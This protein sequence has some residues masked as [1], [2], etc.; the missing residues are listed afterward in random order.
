MFLTKN[1]QQVYNSFFLIFLSQVSFRTLKIHVNCCFVIFSEKS[2]V[3]CWITLHSHHA[4]RSPLFWPVFINWI[5]MVLCLAVTDSCSLS[6]RLWM[7]SS[8]GVS[9]ASRWCLSPPVWCHILGTRTTRTWRTRQP[10]LVMSIARFIRM[11]IVDGGQDDGRTRA[12]R[13]PP[14][15]RGSDRAG[16]EG[17]RLRRGRRSRRHTSLS[18][19]RSS[20]SAGDAPEPAVHLYELKSVVGSVRSTRS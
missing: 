1:I 18:L 14:T 4:C 6:L 16:G 20:K 8:G 13:I 3:G 10:A 17:G 19:A 5:L 2:S 15:R 12:H 9:R 7:M 11:V